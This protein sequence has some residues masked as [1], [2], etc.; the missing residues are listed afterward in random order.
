MKN[1]SISDELFNQL[2]N[3][4][5]DPFDDTIETVIYRLVDITN[6]ARDRCFLPETFPV[7]T[8][9]ADSE[10]EHTPGESSSNYRI[11]VVDE[12]SVL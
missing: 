11:K 8:A 2:K 1:V 7:P 12:G 4:V 3:Y 9:E 5:V 10:W 6:K